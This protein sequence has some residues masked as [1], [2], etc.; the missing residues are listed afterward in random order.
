MS[1]RGEIKLQSH[2]PIIID[3]LA[4][5]LAIGHMTYLHR[6]A[7]LAQIQYHP[8]AYAI[9]TRKRRG[10]HHLPQTT[11]PLRMK[12]LIHFHTLLEDEFRSLFCLTQAFPACPNE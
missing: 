9:K 11:P 10:M 7:F 3:A 5:A 4:S 8:A 6:Q 2:W 12:F 1:A